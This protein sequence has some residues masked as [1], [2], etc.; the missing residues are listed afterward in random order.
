MVE[1][2]WGL[3][4]IATKYKVRMDISINV[5]GISNTRVNGKSQIEGGSAWNPEEEAMSELL[6]LID[7]N[8]DMIT[9][10]FGFNVLVIIQ[11]NGQIQTM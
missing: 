3:S 1:V 7:V 8:R 5:N 10:I 4:C 11:S 6:E 2:I 9:L